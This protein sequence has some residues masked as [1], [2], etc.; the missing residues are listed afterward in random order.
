MKFLIVLIA[1]LSIAP[2]FSQ[3]DALSNQRCIEVY[4]DGYL[5]LRD[6]IILYNEKQLN[7]GEFAGEVSTISTAVNGLRTACFFTESPDVK[8]CVDSY[9]KLYKDLRERVRV[10]SVLTGNQDSVTFTDDARNVESSIDE[11]EN[12]VRRFF[13]NIRNSGADATKLGRLAII[14]AKCR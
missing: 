4:R 14:D 13:R 5:D 11:D 8:E 10:R 9:K 6:A 3:D 12:V 1:A 7:R 2:A